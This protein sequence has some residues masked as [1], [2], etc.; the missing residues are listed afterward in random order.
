M[1]ELHLT[2]VFLFQ[3]PCGKRNPRALT[4]TRP[5]LRWPSLNDVSAKREPDHLVQ[6][7]GPQSLKPVTRLK[8]MGPP[9]HE[10][11][12]AVNAAYAKL[13][14]KLPRRYSQ[15]SDKMIT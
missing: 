5:Q 15:T 4:H 6:V 12:N 8:Q 10:V 2:R 7:A 3:R 11:A 13:T 1:M 14:T 9:L